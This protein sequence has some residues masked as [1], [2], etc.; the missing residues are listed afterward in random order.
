LIID[1]ILPIHKKIKIRLLDWNSNTTDNYHDVVKNVLGTCRGGASA[2]SSQLWS[3]GI[4]VF[5]RG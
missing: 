5:C 1:D 4:D 3:G 2:K